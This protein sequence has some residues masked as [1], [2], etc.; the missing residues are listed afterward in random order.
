MFTAYTTFLI[1]VL[2]ANLG[3]ILFAAQPGLVRRPE[4]GPAGLDYCRPDHAD[5]YSR[6]PL[7]GS[8]VN[9]HDFH[10]VAGHIC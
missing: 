5:L 3:I 9:W 10:D 7:S 1:N 4:P 6:R 8:L 2:Y